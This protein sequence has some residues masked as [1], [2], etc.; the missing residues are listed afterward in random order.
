MN[1]KNF[2]KINKKMPTNNSIH[3]ENEDDISSCYL[4]DLVKDLIETLLKN[5][6]NQKINNKNLNQKFININNDKKNNINNNNLYKN[7]INLLG[8]INHIDQGLNKT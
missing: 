3:E 7:N 6:T 1:N 2:E 5:Q 8:N 4:S